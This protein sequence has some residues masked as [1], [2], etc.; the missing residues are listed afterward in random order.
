MILR[1][2]TI[3]R[4]NAVLLAAILALSLSACSA[5][6]KDGRTAGATGHRYRQ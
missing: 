3:I 2:K 6:K 5:K 4:L 1:R